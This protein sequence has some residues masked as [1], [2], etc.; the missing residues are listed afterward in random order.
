MNTQSALAEE[1]DIDE[2]VNEPQ[3]RIEITPPKQHYQPRALSLG[4]DIELVEKEELQLVN[5]CARFVTTSLVDPDGDD[6]EGGVGRGEYE[7]PVDGETIPSHFLA[8]L[9]FSHLRV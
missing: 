8:I 1:E 9:M 4:S 2:Y 7:E 6:N 5:K 3:Y